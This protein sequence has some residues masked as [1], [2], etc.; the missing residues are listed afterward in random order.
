MRVLDWR[1]PIIKSSHYLFSFIM[2]TEDK[3]LAA[4]R[5]NLKPSWVHRPLI[6]A[7]EAKA[8]GFL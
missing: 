6:P 5:K 2:K 7:L 8:G 4:V 3:K 1:R